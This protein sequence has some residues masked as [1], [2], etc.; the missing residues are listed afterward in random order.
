MEPQYLYLRWQ[1]TIL[2]FGIVQDISAYALH[3]RLV[4]FLRTSFVE[5]PGSH[6]D[7]MSF[8]VLIFLELFASVLKDSHGRHAKMGIRGM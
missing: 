3:L 2:E 8:R 7:S 6:L 4:R 1:D 5:N